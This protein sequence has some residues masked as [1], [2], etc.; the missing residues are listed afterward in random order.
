MTTSGPDIDLF[1]LFG[2]AEMRLVMEALLR[3]PARQGK[4]A[5]QLGIDTR[6][7]GV[8]VRKLE[9]AGLV[10][11]TS[12]RGD[13]E[14]THFDATAALLEAEAS[15]SREI[16]ELKVE[17]AQRRSRE[18]RKSRM[19]GGVNTSAEGEAAADQ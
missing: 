2:K 11:R 10:A 4:L 18:L 19:Q 15:L 13:I 16:Q 7:L 3:G 9:A 6:P 12:A 8:A 1:A 14:L 17:K 5:D